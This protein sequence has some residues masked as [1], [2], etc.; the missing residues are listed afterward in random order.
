MNP[1]RKLDA[2]KIV[3][4]LA[5]LHR[6]IAERFPDSG[7]AEVSKETLAV[8]RENAGRIRKIL[9][10]DPL[11][12]ALIL[13]ILAGGV[14]ILLAVGISLRAGRIDW[15]P[16]SGSELIQEIEAALATVVFLGAAVVYLTSLERRA[17]C[18]RTLQAIHELRSLAHIV[19]MHQLTKDPERVLLP[20]T[21]T[22]SSPK[23][24]LTPFLLSRYLDYCSELLALIAKVGAL[25][26][27][28]L[29]DPVT[30][31]AVDDIED[32]TS[33]LC[34]KIWQKIMLLDRIMPGDGSQP[35]TD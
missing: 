21:D 17:K 33:G 7:L 6:R 4:T 14:A 2:E 3:E 11:L 9:R 28:S 16:A 18:S 30:L 26:A 5:T 13:L 27:Q 23:R 24:S 1:Y 10:P 29:D 22:E 15:R 19:D 32:L 20:G 31:S 34:R 12:R 8:A 25:Y 35:Q